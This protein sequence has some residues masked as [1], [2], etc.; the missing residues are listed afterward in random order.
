VLKA[1]VSEGH[2]TARIGGDE[3]IVIMPDADLEKA[4]ELIERIQS[5]VVMNNKYYREPELSLSLGAAVSGPGLSLEKVIS[6]ADN[7]MYRNKG[8]YHRRRKED[9]LGGGG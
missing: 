3:F 1:S 7:E 9:Y 6:L 5:L 8:I 4:T 2:L